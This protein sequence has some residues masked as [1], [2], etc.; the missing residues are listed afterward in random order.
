MIICTLCEEEFPSF[1]KVLMLPVV[2]LILISR[3]DYFPH[4]LDISN[5]VVELCFIGY[6]LI[7]I[8]QYSLFVVIAVKEI[9][10]YLNIYIFSIAD[11]LQ[12]EA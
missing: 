11:S 3:V 5:S 9:A 8:I 1:Q 2:W 10:S 4:Y 7:V 12:L 6:G